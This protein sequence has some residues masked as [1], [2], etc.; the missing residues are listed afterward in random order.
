MKIFKFEI[1]LL[2][3]LIIFTQ[4][5][6]LG[7]DNNNDDIPESFIE[8][9]DTLIYKKGSDIPFTGKEKARI[10]NKII[11]YDVVDGLKHGDFRLYYESGNIE[12]KGQLDKNKNI[13]KWQYFY[14]SG[15][16]ESEGN[17]V[18]N[19]PDGEWKWYYRSGELRE[20]GIFKGGK[21]VGFWKLFDVSG[22]VIEEKEF[23]E[24]DS[25]NTETDY[26]EK[27][28]NNLN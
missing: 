17:F 16:I 13:G 10:E 6:F 27:L 18:D 19:F 14:E 8:M 24:S 15:Q 11:E 1:S 20:Q 2:S 4:F 5:F 28:K 26:L 7:C 23:F 21:R 12:I 22:N 3:A 9:R 25:L